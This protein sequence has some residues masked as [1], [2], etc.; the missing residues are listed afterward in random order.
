VPGDVDWPAKPT[1]VLNTDEVGHTL[2]TRPD[3]TSF[4]PFQMWLGTLV[5]T[6]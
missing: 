1:A 3:T 6:S 4:L 2:V 5:T